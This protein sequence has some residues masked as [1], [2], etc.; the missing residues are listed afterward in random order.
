[1]AAKRI[2]IGQDP[3]LQGSAYFLKCEILAGV[4]NMLLDLKAKDDRN[5]IGVRLLQGES[6]AS[7]ARDALAHRRR[8]AARVARGLREMAIWVERAAK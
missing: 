4:G 3:A 8:E 6:R 7:V 5:A 2:P 1:M